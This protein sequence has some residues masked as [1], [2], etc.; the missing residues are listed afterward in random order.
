[1][2]A[3]QL[4]KGARP[5]IDNIEENREIVVALREIAANKVKYKKITEEERR[6]S[7][8]EKIL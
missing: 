2:R 1:L 8:E 4:M 3:H 5:T 7:V 6:R